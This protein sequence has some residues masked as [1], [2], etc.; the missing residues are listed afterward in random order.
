MNRPKEHG[1]LATTGPRQELGQ[2]LR[3]HRER[4]TPAQAGIATQRAR[5][6]PGLRREEVAFLADIGAKW[7]AKLEMGDD[8][9]PSMATLSG[10]ARALQLTA[11]ETDYLFNLAGLT[12]PKPSLE[13]NLEIPKEL[14]LLL[15][16]IVEF[17]ALVLDRVNTALRWNQLGDAVFG[18][19]NFS[20]LIERNGIVRAFTDP[21]YRAFFGVDFE[22]TGREAVGMLRRCYAAGP[23]SLFV[24]Q[25]F[26]RVKDEPLFAEIWEERSISEEVAVPRIFARHHPEFGTF[27]ASALNLFMNRRDDI[28]LRILF[29]ADDASKAT[30][31]ALAAHGK[32]WGK[33]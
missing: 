5:R 16:S 23:P 27:S 19:S 7:Y 3:A 6:T 14:E 24:Q 26:E 25:I 32:P 9:N 20:T 30:F 28:F 13:E 11:P 33:T 17:P 4:L 8:V 31:A 29:P 22:R 21:R 2:F 18:C 1:G 12:A 10:I 15:S